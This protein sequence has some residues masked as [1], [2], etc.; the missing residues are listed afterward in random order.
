MATCLIIVKLLIERKIAEAKKDTLRAFEYAGI[1]KKHLEYC[2]SCREFLRGISMKGKLDCE[3]VD[4]PGFEID[5]NHLPF[6]HD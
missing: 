3:L 5:D 1:I 6:K 4:H 2:P